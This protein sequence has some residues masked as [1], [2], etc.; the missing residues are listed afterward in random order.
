MKKILFVLVIIG[1]CFHFHASAQGNLQF[2]RVLL[3]SDTLKTVPIGKVWKIESIAINASGT[4]PQ[5]YGSL[6]ITGSGTCANTDDSN[7]YFE[8]NGNKRVCSGIGNST[9]ATTVPASSCFPFWL[10]EGTT[11]KTQCPDALLS[12]IEFNICPRECN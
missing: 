7:A 6:Q 9:S 8:I 3:V 4:L 11:L 1:A 12:V 10:P 2:S 5:A